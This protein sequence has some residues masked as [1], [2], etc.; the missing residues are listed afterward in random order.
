MFDASRRRDT[1]QRG[2]QN[3][4]E[5]SAREDYI[6]RSGL[7]RQW[8]RATGPLGRRITGALESIRRGITGPLGDASQQ[9]PRRNYPQE[10]R[11]ASGSDA[12]HSQEG[13]SEPSEAIEFRLEK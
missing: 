10:V 3:A 4:P 7:S 9:H 5:V 6:R 13:T 2:T 12:P 8:H 11:V 1:Q